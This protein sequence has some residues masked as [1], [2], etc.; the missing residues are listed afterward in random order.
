MAQLSCMLRKLL[1]CYLIQL[2]PY[3]V[4][5]QNI[6]TGTVRDYNNGELLFGANVIIKGT[7]TG[8][9]TDL[10]GKFSIKTADG[11][12][13]TLVASYIGYVTQ[14]VVIKNFT[15]VIIRLKPDKVMLSG[16]E[17][18]GSRI[19][20]K[21]KEAPLTVEAMDLIAIKETPATGFY[22]GLGQLKGVDLTAASF[23]FKIINTRGFN[24]SSP[25]RSLQ[26]IDGVDNQS[27]GLNF[28]LGNFL[29]AP[30]LDVQKVEIIQGASSAFY[31]PNAFNGVISMTTRNPFINPGL[32]VSFKVGERDLTEVSFRWAEYF[33]NKKGEPKFA[34]KLNMY[35]LQARDWE[36]NNLSATPQSR[37][38]RTNPGGY[39]AVNIYGDEYKNGYDY[40]NDAF[41]LP[42][43]GTIYRKGYFEKDLVDYNT[44]NGKI[45]AAFHYKIK[46]DV[47]AIASSNFGTGTTIYQGDNRYS[48]KDILFLQNRLEIKRDDRWFI[49]GYATHEDAGKS[50]DAFF[51]AL[52]LQR[53]AKP[54]KNYSVDYWM[55]DYVN[56]WQT[57]AT[58][59][60]KQLPG[61]PQP[62]PG[63]TG[64][65]FIQ[66]VS[67]I[68]PFLYTNYLDTLFYF[69]QLAQT[70]ANGI[71]NPLNSALPFYEPGS[72]E[73][74]TAFAGITS[75]KTFGQ[76]GSRFF[77]RSAL[78]H[79]HG[80]YKFT[81]K[82][83]E[84]TVGGNH[85]WYKPYS[86][87]TIF[88][89]TSYV[90]YRIEGN[91]T[92]GKDTVYRKITNKE[93]GIYAGIEKRV[94]DDKL[95]FNVTCRMD[96]NQNF[97][98]LFSPA[99]SVV[100][101]PNKNQMVRTSFSSAI[102]NPTLTDQ[103]LYYQVGRAILIGN[104]DG[105]E[106][107]VTIPSLISFFN[108]NKSFDSL[109]FFN[110]KAVR[111]EEV[112]TV[113]L[114]YRATLF[115][116]LYLDIGGYHSWYKYFIGFKFGAD[117]DTFSITNIFGTYK[118]LRFNNVLRVATN[119]EDE[120]VT[121]G[122]NAGLNYYYGKYLSFSGNYSWNK[123][124]RKGAEDPLIPAFNT[125]EHK[126][127]IGMTV[128]DFKNWGFSINY[129]WIDG[130]L[131]EGSPQ[132]SGYI[133]SY[134]MVD[135]QI[136]RYLPEMFTTLKLGASNVL[137][138]K[139]YEIYGGPLVGRV[140]Y[141]SILVELNERKISKP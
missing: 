65:C 90:Q 2:I 26:I 4:F 94:M 138:N 121:M 6:I 108:Y 69:H 126:F 117:V 32:E 77:D 111:P 81:P 88:S 17:I 95:R 41:N 60:L 48:L 133:D 104:K 39:D 137:D 11:V 89:D 96:K 18:T 139:H 44:K 8:A 58:P 46:K 122:V 128:R 3:H 91:D 79:V 120:V 106:N 59:V 131:F 19:S 76:G 125:P 66:Y 103:Y 75:R 134:N 105:Y 119:S 107:L 31:G 43:L 40:S 135:V 83:A 109:S 15:P 29:G 130:F 51:T 100:F 33:K 1:F 82:W 97:D 92:I 101:V 34:Y 10:D 80:E 70:F 71:G 30:E 56:Y 52:L 102:R 140:A 141:F 22:E 45:G 20:E 127:N 37:N 68:N 54:D 84:I 36:A 47:E 53:S 78:Y 115:K 124:D 74:D 13:L 9:V 113:E 49:R 61:F 93:F 116:N 16:V 132:F 86:Q 7:S 99:A 123:L 55:Q 42:G 73:F 85:R 136:S 50:Y 27:P 98:Y 63:C 72:Y 35:F 23:G 12:P 62:P 114:G 14:E 129:K 38:D 28:S 112:K 64:P 118:D 21:Q 87:G 67:T 24:S 25:V 57:Y 110:V 5:S